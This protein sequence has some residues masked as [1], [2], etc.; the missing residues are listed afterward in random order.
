MGERLGPA[1][2]YRKQLGAARLSKMRNYGLWVEYIRMVLAEILCKI[3]C[4]LI[5]PNIYPEGEIK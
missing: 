1:H 5:G 3:L 4:G 2:V